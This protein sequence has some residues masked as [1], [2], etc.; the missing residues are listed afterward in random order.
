MS[1][2][3]TYSKLNFKQF[4]FKINV[5]ML[6]KKLKIKKKLNFKINVWQSSAWLHPIFYCYTYMLC[7]CLLVNDTSCKGKGT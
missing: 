1:R 6:K 4:L 3:K 7:I 5:E 2:V